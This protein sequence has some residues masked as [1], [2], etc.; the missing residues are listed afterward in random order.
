MDDKLEQK[1]SRKWMVT[2]NNPDVH[3]FTH[4]KIC[5]IM[6]GVKGESLYWCLCDEEG[7]E[8]ETRHTHIFIYRSS[9]FTARQIDNLFPAMHRDICVGKAV[10]CRAYILKEGDKYNKQEDGTYLYADGNGKVHSG[11]NFSDTFEEFGILPDEHQGRSGNADLILAMVR[12]GA[13]T[14]DIVAAV[15]SAYRD[16][17]RIDRVR[18]M[19][20]DAHFSSEWRDVETTYIYGDTGTGKTRSVMDRYG[21]ASCYRVTDYKHPFDTY[22]GEDVIIFEEY[23]SCFPISDILNYLDGYPLLLPC[24]YF[25]RRACY[26]KV[27]IVT[28]IPPEEQYRYEDSASREAFFRR[29]HKVVQLTEMGKREWPGMKE[30]INDD[31]LPFG[32]SG[33][34]EQLEMEEVHGCD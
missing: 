4:D 29:I 12:D 16:I 6:S 3:G 32:P 15:P 9:P 17:D 24:R 27:F 10:E 19:L 13:S 1:Q 20:R 21:Y 5:E 18:S 26:T 31:I 25:D 7:D 33:V 2:I 28:N 8:C 11:T 14:A 30:Y 23:R 22:N 34:F